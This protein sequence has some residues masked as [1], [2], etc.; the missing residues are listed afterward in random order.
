MLNMVKEIIII[1]KMC[2]VIGNQSSHWLSGWLT[3]CYA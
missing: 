1:I 3:P 2:M